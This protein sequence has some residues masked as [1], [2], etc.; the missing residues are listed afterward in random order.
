MLNFILCFLFAG[1]S[2]ANGVCYGK[3]GCF[4]RDKPF[5]NFWVWLP[6]DTSDVG[7][8][9]HLYTRN[10]REIS[11]VIDDND[12]GKLKAS[13][14]DISRRTILVIHGFMENKNKWATRMKDALLA[15]EDCNVILV[16]W[17]KGARFPY[18]RASGNTRLVGTQTA[19]LIRFLISSSS[20]SAGLAERFYIVGFS[21]GAVT[22]G[23][24]GS[25]LK[26]HEM[27]LGRITGL[28]PAGPYFTNVNAAVRL[29]PGDAEYV[30]VIHTD[31]GRF[32]TSRKV[33]HIDF[34]PNGG[35]DQ[36]GCRFS[37]IQLV[38]SVS[39]EHMRAT[40]YYIATVQN[41]CSWKAY[42]CTSYSD[43]KK[44]KCQQ[45]NG[46]C[47]TMGYGADHTK[48]SGTFYL[49]TNHK[50]PFCGLN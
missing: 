15:R 21:L 20:G 11:Q 45:C 9:F 46:E 37:I 13:N 16:D 49:K 47:P 1:A 44:G 43:F 27:M 14:F 34:F 2:T 39:C 25:H 31:A 3:Y 22:A 7:T 36:P 8:S 48:C 17:S 35:Y 19:E 38:K 29:D 33:G 24:A 40:E 26:K 41:R 42:P 10:N 28:D 23:Y 32:G 5:N 12:E 4:T 50:A 6:Q 18:G 30:D